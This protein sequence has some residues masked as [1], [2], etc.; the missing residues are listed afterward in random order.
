MQKKCENL[1][2]ISKR[3]IGVSKCKSKKIEII[4]GPDTF[5]VLC[6]KWPVFEKNWK[7]LGKK[8]RVTPP[9]LYETLNLTFLYLDLG[10]Q[11]FGAGY[12]EDFFVESQFEVH[13]VLLLSSS[14]ENY[15]K[16]RSIQF[17]VFTRFHMC[18]CLVNYA[19][20]LIWN[21]KWTDV[22]CYSPLCPRTAAVSSSTDYFISPP[23]G[24]TGKA[25]QGF[26]SPL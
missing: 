9:P 19:H 22:N 5:K 25:F 17:I 13:F 16:P 12:R 24:W 15:E 1:F 18:Y 26:I 2:S 20:G 11:I 3:R 6:P 7:I 21:G 10:F 14:D 23:L 8:S 4:F